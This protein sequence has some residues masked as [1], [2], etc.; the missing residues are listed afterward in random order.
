[1]MENPGKKRGRPPSHRIRVVL[2]I[3]PRAN[4]L[5][6]QAAKANRL[7]KGQ[8][9]EYCLDWLESIMAGISHRNNYPSSVR[10]L[11]KR[12]VS[13]SDQPE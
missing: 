11:P 10:R 13:G 6:A 12:K 4:K 2:K 3:S 5:L 9:I 7:S 1:M 8:F